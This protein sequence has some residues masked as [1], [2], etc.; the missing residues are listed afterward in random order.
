MD[1]KFLFIC[2]K[3][4]R[5]SSSSASYLLI[6]LLNHADQEVFISHSLSKFVSPP[7]LYLLFFQ[8]HEIAPRVPLMCSFVTASLPLGRFSI[9]CHHHIPHVCNHVPLTSSSDCIARVSN[10]DNNFFYHFT[11]TQFRFHFRHYHSSF[12]WCTYSL[13]SQIPLSGVHFCKMLFRF[14]TGRQRDQIT[15]C[16]AV[17]TWKVAEQGP[18]TNTV[19]KKWHDWTVMMHTFYLCSICG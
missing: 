6:V 14:I 17:C 12:P 16:F 11:Y 7:T 19:C 3:P 8:H 10:N 4:I 9:F 13:V 5:S 18:I 1:L 2:K 15:T